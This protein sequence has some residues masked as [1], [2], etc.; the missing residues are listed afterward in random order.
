MQTAKSGNIHSFALFIFAFIYSFMM[1]V[2]KYGVHLYITAIKNP[3]ADIM[4]TLIGETIGRFLG[5]VF[6]AFILAT[7]VAFVIKI[8]NKS[9]EIERKKVTRKLMQ[10]FLMFIIIMNLLKILFTLKL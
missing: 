1:V 2:R 6:V 7:I 4:I 8:I 5:I 9:S 10:F 3:T